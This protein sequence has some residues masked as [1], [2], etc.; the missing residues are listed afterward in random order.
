VQLAILWREVKIVGATDGLI[1]VLLVAALLGGGRRLWT[2][3]PLTQRAQRLLPWVWVLAVPA[4]YVGRGV[5]VVSRYLL[6]LLPVL[7]WLA[8]RAGE[9]WSLGPVEI[10]LGEATPRAARR[11]ALLGVAFAALVL[12]QNLVVY[13]A[14]VVPQVNSFTAGLSESLIPWAHWLRQHTPPSTV[15]ATPDIGALGYFSQRRIL[16]LGGL[17]TPEM[18]PYLQHEEYE[19]AT[20]NFRFAAFS[21]PGYLVDRGPRPDDLRHRSRFAPALTLLGVTS[22]PNLGIAQPG[23]VFYS[24]YRIDWPEADSILLSR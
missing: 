14:M 8:W 16:D 21:R 7:S 22:V 1:A 2:Q 24:L 5:P 13:R 9:C 10:G 23:R 17:V 20:A 6:P 12:L 15:I 18:V 3:R 19:E 4:L 11:T